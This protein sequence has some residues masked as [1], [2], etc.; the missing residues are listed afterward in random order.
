M[1]QFQDE[2]MPPVKKKPLRLAP[3]TSRADAAKAHA[4]LGEFLRRSAAGGAV[5]ASYEGEGDVGMEGDG[6]SGA[7]NDGAGGYG[8]GGGGGGG[9]GGGAGGWAPVGRVDAMHLSALEEIRAEGAA[10]AAGAASKREQA[11]AGS[12][13]V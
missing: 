11:D 6:G 5:A 13:Q 1:L 7:G 3:Q 4:E 12:R 10:A 9:G 2:E 8:A